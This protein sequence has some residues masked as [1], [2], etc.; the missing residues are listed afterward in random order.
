MSTKQAKENHRRKGMKAVLKTARRPAQE[1]VTVEFPKHN[2]TV[3]S[4]RYTLRIGSPG[5]GPVEVSI[6]GGEWQSCRPSAGFWW[7]DWSGY[8][9]GRH[10]VVARVTGDD[11]VVHRGEAVGFLVKLPR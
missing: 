1:R 11:G 5:S 2:E 10:E 6:D 3:E 8:K 7:F 4:E 9:P